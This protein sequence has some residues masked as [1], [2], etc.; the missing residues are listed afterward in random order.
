MIGDVVGGRSSASSPSAEKLQ[1]LP[2]VVGSRSSSSSSPKFGTTM[3]GISFSNSR[4]NSE[5]QS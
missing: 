3:A 5:A 1:V 2:G 4:S